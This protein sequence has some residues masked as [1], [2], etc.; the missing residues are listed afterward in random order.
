VLGTLLVAALAVTA[1]VSLARRRHGT[2]S[3]R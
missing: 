3:S 2:V 1:A